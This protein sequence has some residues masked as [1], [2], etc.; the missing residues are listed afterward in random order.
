LIWARVVTMNAQT[1]TRESTILCFIY[2]LVF[3]TANMKNKKGST[4]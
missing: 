1:K 4:Q 2:T 3:G